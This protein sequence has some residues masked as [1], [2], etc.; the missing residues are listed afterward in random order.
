M[1]QGGSKVKSTKIWLNSGSHI[2][3]FCYIVDTKNQC[4]KELQEWNNMSEILLEL[5]WK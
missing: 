1:I 3:H 2:C 5:L 4:V